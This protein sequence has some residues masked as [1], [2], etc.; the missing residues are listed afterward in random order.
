MNI[1][2]LEAAALKAKEL[3]LMGCKHDISLLQISAVK[4]QITV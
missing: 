3:K 1:F 4:I 2:S